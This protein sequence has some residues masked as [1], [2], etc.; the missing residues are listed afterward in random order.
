VTIHISRR[1]AGGGGPPTESRTVQ[2]TGN[3]E[4]NGNTFDETLKVQGEVAREDGGALPSAAVM[5]KNMDTGDNVPLAIRHEDEDSSTGRLLAS[6]GIYELSLEEPTGVV[7]GVTGKGAK[8]D[9]RK[10]TLGA[11][12]EVYLKVVVALGEGSVNGVALHD[13]KMVEGAMMLLVPEED[14]ANIA[15]Y[16]RD[17]S[18]SDGTFA[19]ANVVAGKY[20]VVGIADGWEL[21]WSRREV[22]EKYLARGT[23]VEVGTGVVA[24]V[25]V[26]VQ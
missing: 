20:V 15:L 19:F 9:G 16:R 3:T 13:G 5:L 14:A 8:V 24:G 7:V 10:I 22:V 21:E 4:L 6:P 18:D 26:E 2:L 1:T 17:Q 11:E 23:K 12:K 25:K